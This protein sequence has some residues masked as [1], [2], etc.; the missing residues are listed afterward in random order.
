MSE[1]F[2][3]NAKPKGQVN[4]RC[5]AALAQALAGAKRGEF[6]SAAIVVVG[7]QGDPLV[8]FGGRGEDSMA[9]NFGLD[10]IKAQLVSRTSA[11]STP[12]TPAK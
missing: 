6:V 3:I 11:P 8:L 9:V 4:D 1:P 2:D 5:V 10:L 12:I 7:A